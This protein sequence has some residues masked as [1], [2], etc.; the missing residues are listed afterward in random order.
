MPKLGLSR[1]EI[2]ERKREALKWGLKTGAM[3]DVV[4]TYRRARHRGDGELT[5]LNETANV[6]KALGRP[7]GEVQDTVRVLIDWAIEHHRDWFYKF[8]R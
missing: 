5:A 7:N 1:E 8:E 2:A 6:A 4:R 3:R